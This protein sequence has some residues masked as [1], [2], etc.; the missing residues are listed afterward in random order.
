[1]GSHTV[2]ACGEMKRMKVVYI[3]S[4]RALIYIIILEGFFYKLIFKLHVDKQQQELTILCLI[5]WPWNAY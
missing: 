4:T 2:N 5:I 3:I 1:M